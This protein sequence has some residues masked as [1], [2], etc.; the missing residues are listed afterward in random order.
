MT[1]K[2]IID[3]LVNKYGVD[4]KGLNKKNL[5]E[6][7]KLLNEQEFIND[8]NE[9]TTEID[10][11]TEVILDIKENEIDYS[12]EFK[13]QLDIYDTVVKR[14]EL[15]KDVKLTNLGAGDLYVS[16]TK[17]DLISD[18]NLIRPNEFKKLQNVKLIYMTSASRPIVQINY[19]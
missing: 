9:G 13:L 7:R 17:D 5:T 14:F 11:L 6:L 10:N 4:S 12:N 1:K 3:L 8:I 2:E 16:D 19:S 15:A 18:K